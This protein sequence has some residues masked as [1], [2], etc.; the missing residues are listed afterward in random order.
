MN[1][2]NNNDNN[3]NVEKNKS[4]ELDQLAQWNARL[5][6]INNVNNNVGEFETE[7]KLMESILV[8]SVT[9]KSSLAG[10]S[11]E[12]IFLLLTIIQMF[13]NQKIT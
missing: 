12:K 4:F 7:F 8:L 3:A 5:T 2:N 10:V 11:A 6:G 9:N 1:S 13:S